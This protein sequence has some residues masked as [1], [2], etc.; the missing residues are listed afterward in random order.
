MAEENQGNQGGGMG[1]AI[2]TDKLESSRSHARQAAEDLRNAATQMAGDYR[3]RAEQAWT[4]AQS[5]ARTLQDDGEQY[6][7]ENPVKAVFTALGVGFILG[8][9][10]RK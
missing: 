3:G 4:D 6:V 5:R 8:L 1:G 2:P 10:F 9:L 7:R